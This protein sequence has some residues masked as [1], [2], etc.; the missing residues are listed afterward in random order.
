MNYKT[1]AAWLTIAFAILGA[2]SVSAANVKFELDFEYTGGHEPSG[3]PP[4]LV[5]EF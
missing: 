2:V 1:L 3:P 4:W 5:A